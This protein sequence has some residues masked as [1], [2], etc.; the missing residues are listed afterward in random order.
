MH[1]RPSLAFLLSALL[2]LTSTLESCGGD[3][4]TGTTTTPDTT[5]AA[6]T[7]VSGTNQPAT[8]G[9]A[10]PL[11]F[12]VKVTNSAGAGLSGVTVTWAILTGGGSLSPT[13]STTG[14]GGTA[15][16]NYTAGTA[17][18][19]SIITATVSGLGPVTFTAIVSAPASG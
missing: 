16:T 17:A 9:T 11:P 5:P 6:I 8:I 19:T 3:S 10:L 1:R 15:S 18:G 7:V 2:P 12:V 13:T 4:S 14:S